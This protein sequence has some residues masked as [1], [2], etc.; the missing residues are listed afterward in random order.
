MQIICRSYV[1][2]IPLLTLRPSY[3][4][5]EPNSEVDERKITFRLIHGGKR[6]YEGVFDGSASIF[7]AAPPPLLHLLLLELPSVLTAASLGSGVC[8]GG[9]D[10]T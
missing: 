3:S 4:P 1:L 9:V 6:E 8:V 5:R 10:P 2:Q 7:G